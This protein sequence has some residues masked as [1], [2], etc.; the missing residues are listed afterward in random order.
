MRPVTSTLSTTPTMTCSTRYLIANA[1]STLATRDA[2]DHGADETDER[3][4][5]DARQE[6]RGERA[7]EQLPL[8]R[9][10]HDA[11][12]LADDAAESSE[13]QGHR[14]RDRTEQQARDGHETAG[15]RPERGTRT[16]ASTLN[17][18][19]SHSEGAPVGPCPKERPH[20]QHHEDA[21][22]DPE[23]RSRGQR[24]VRQRERRG[25]VGEAER[26]R[27]VARHEQ[28][29][30]REEHG[31]AGEDDRR[32]EVPFLHRRQLDR[33]VGGLS[34]HEGHHAAT[35]F[36]AAL[37]SEPGRLLDIGLREEEHR[38]QQRRRGDEQHHER[39]HDE[40]DVD[41]DVLRLHGEGPCLERAE[42]DAGG[43]RAPGA[44]AAEE[45]DGDRV[46]ADPGID[47]LGDARGDRALDLVH[48]R[49]TGEATGEEHGVDV[50]ALDADARGA[51][52]G[53]GSPPRRALRIAER[54]AL[55]EPPDE[56]CRHDHDHEAEVEQRELRVRAASGT[57]RSP[58]S[59][60]RAPGSSPAS[61]ADPGCGSSTA[62][63]STRCSSA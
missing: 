10:V 51:R 22:H 52:G 54:R 21:D 20:R 26:A 2:A 1:A 44:T 58:A 4:A 36:F 50:D 13:D 34:L 5:R 53:A 49:E 11:G 62:A 24:H 35:A 33:A 15:G 38:A 27:A 41:R 46:E 56:Q 6:R 42:Q 43:E 48:A 28:E 19:T 14:E 40:H 3:V 37:G 57:G 30:Q 55:D 8:D 45:G 47:G 39:L 32:L 59:P 7:Q 25:L 18:I 63:G 12:T 16:T 23:G 60:I 31:G 17:A 29:Q 61:A 9:D